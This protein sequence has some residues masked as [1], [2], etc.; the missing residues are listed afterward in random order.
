MLA[1]DPMTLP[2]IGERARA[3]AVPEQYPVLEIDLTVIRANW[4]AMA[5]RHAGRVMSAVVKSD[6]YGLG[7]DRVAA[8]LAGAGCG[9]FWVNDLDE[10]V[11]LRMAL[12]D[13][14]VYALFGL[15]L[16]SPVNFAGTGIVPVLSSLA[17]V[18]YC[19]DAARRGGR[20]MP[21]AVQLDTGLGRLGL[22]GSDVDRL[23]E[24]RDLLDALD[25]RCWVS[26]LAA[27]DLPEEPSNLRQRAALVD[28]VGRLKPAPISLAS[29]AAMYM[30]AD[31]HF[32]I[33][34]IGSALF[35][36]QTS[37]HW[38]DGIRPCYRLRAPV[39]RVAN[40]QAG[41]TL[42]YRGAARLERPSRIATTILGYANGLPQAFAGFGTARF[43]DHAAPFVGG[44]SMNLSMLDVTDLPDGA[45]TAGAR[46]IVFDEDSTIDRAA[47]MHGCAPNALLTQIGGNTRRR[48]LDEPTTPT[49]P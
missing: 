7:L 39:L 34:R 16:H 40:L 4:R 9:T 30:G 23:A 49:T 41:S 43:G 38:Q 19:A 20:R 2:S 10:A 31:W 8:T 35:G 29:S 17:E 11:R 32:D 37:V 45:A 33:A 36:V 6:A 21:V 3:V 25:V 1:P 26:H 14:T 5:A 47:A 18:E 15:G 24:R 12:P 28:W 44:L 42:G 48:Y 46:C 22:T 27:F 13:V